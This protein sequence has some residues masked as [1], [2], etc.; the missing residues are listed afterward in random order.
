MSLSDSAPPRGLKWRAST[1]FIV[2]TVG[3]GAF[4]D[5]F[6]YGLIVPVLP[7]M[8]KDRVNLPDSEIQSTVSNL[9]AIYAAASVAT[10]PIA[11]ILAD[12]CSN[13]R[14]LPFVLGLVML[15][16]A[17]V[18]LAVG[19]TVPVLALARFLQGA[20]AGVVWTIGLAI[21]IETVGQE[22]LGTTMGTI[23]SFVS[24]AA[25]FSPILGGLLYASVGYKGVFGLG[26]GLVGIDFILRLLMIEKKAAARYEKLDASQSDIEDTTEGT[27]QTPL[28]PRTST[29]HDRY[30]LPKPQNRVTRTLPILLIFR[31]PGL[32]TA[33]WISFMQASLLGAF[34]ATVPLVSSQ[35]FGFN[36]LK[37]GLLFIP[38]GGADFLF[39]PVFGW[40]VDRYDDAI[41]DKLNN[42]RHVALYA[43]LLAVNGIGL[44][45]I[46]S[47]A[48]VEAGNIV[49]KYYQANKDV[50]EQAPYAQLYGISSMVFSGGLTVGPL[51]AGYLR[52]RIG[53]GN[54]NA[55]FA[56]ICAA[57]AI[58][59]AVFMGRKE[60][61]LGEEDGVDE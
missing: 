60:E 8:L 43:G 41:T 39:G 30:R 35:Q 36:S 46:N 51:L 29:A 25:L 38:L 12:K 50:F 4:T 21:I 20:S 26:I 56:G 18:L 22:N 9:L 59:A 53:Y 11:G 61:N 58:P 16:L 3:M 49:E 14:K 17:T 48:I 6:L 7:Y 32:L 27:E 42:A 44:A 31:D 5:L 40:C 33:I 47:P 24:V 10:S 1:Y 13:S 45:V 55:V 52:E 15:V 23:F 34:D 37:A 28:L 19:Q 54:M 57:T 2:F